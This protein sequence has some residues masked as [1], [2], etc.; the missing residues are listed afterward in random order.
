MV[1]NDSFII[2]SLPNWEFGADNTGNIMDRDNVRA[3]RARVLDVAPVDI[4]TGDG[5]MGCDEDPE[6]QE[7]MT[8]RLV[9]YEVIA[10][11][12]VLKPHGC[13]IIKMFTT[14]TASS[15]ACIAFMASLFRRC[16]MLKP[17]T[18]KSSNSEIYV[19][20]CDFLGLPSEQWFDSLLDSV[21]SSHL[22]A[23]SLISP[24][25]ISPE[26]RALYE[27]ASRTFADLTIFNLH[28]ILA[29]VEPRGPD[30]PPLLPEVD[31]ARSKSLWSA[32]F[33]RRHS[34]A[35]LP[36]RLWIAQKPTFAPAPPRVSTAGTWKSD[37]TQTNSEKPL[38]RAT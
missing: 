12:G 14:F 15:M 7:I 6:Q 31:L 11:I 32:I 25:L 29:F 36:A 5:G 35:N 30:A 20:G 8:G 23:R 9:M 4:F 37:A 2:N 28:R 17:A 33:G 19:V 24:E 34:I 13:M 3:F 22:D 21:S 27:T 1:D 38:L 18:S 16:Y 26:W 10:G